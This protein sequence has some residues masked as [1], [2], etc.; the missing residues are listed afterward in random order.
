MRKSV[1]SLVAVVALSITSCGSNSKSAADIN[2]SELDSACG[3]V[4]AMEVVFDEMLSLI[5]GKTEEQI[6]SDEDIKKQVKSLEDI[7]EK[8]EDRCMDELNFSREEAE[9]CPNFNKAK[10]KMDKIED[11][12]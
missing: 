2:V 4:D 11:I 10:E 5:D 7:Y 1:L 8:I 9:A 3:C 12:L 6:D